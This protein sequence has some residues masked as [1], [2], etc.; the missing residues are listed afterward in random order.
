MA[1]FVKSVM[2]MNTSFKAKP[3]DAAT[4][5][6][7]EDVQEAAADVDVCRFERFRFPTVPITSLRV[8]QNQVNDMIILCDDQL[9]QLR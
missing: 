3:E 8:L 7:F 1:R 9:R 4:K 6:L 2:K 5:Q